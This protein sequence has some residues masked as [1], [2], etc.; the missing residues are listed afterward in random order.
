M[1]NRLTRRLGDLTPDATGAVQGPGRLILLDQRGALLNARLYNVL[2]QAII[3]AL[4]G[5]WIDPQ[6]RVS[7]KQETFCCSSIRPDVRMA[8]ASLI[9]A[10]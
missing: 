5:S 2:H 6:S 3:H 9:Y 10:G 1:R 7:L 4:T 8:R